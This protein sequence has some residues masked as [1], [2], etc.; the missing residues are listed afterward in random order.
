LHRTIN[1]ATEVLATNGSTE[2]LYALTQGMLQPGDEVIAFE[3]AF[4][5][6]LYLIQANSKFPQFI[7][8]LVHNVCIPMILL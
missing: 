5:I 7:P 2:A 8:F 1:P 4:D 6:Y 3:P